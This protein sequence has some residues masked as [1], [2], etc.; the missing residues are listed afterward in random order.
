M[1]LLLW[2]QVQDGNGY[3]PQLLSA[4]LLRSGRVRK[5][6]HVQQQLAANQQAQA[7]SLKL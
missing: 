3:G 2:Q 5:L 7:A 4:L 1:S 6:Q